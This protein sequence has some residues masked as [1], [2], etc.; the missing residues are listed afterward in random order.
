MFPAPRISL[1]F[2][3]SENCLVTLDGW[4]TGVCFFIVTGSWHLFTWSSLSVTRAHLE[5]S[6]EKWNRLLA[7]L[8]E[9]IKW[10]NMKDEELKKQMP[11]GGDVPA[12]QLQ[13]DHCKVSVLPL[14]VFLFILNSILVN[15]WSEIL[16][17]R[18]V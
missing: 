15:K 14:T 1:P 11:I 7:S 13:Y 5:A 6:A 8:E 18:K 12:L 3:G 2:F 9:L 16:E 17:K 4:A 10:L